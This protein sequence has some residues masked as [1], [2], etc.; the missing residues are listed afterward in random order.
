MIQASRK[1]SQAKVSHVPGFRE[2]LTWTQKLPKRPSE[3]FCGVLASRIK[4]KRLGQRSREPAW[5]LQSCATAPARRKAPRSSLGDD[6]ATAT[7]SLS[8]TCPPGRVRLGLGELRGTPAGP[9]GA[10]G[11]PFPQSQRASSPR[12][13]SPRRRRRCR[14]PGAPSL[15]A[16]AFIGHALC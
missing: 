9:P 10:G 2:A 14:P 7:K 3:M 13:G 15:R 16:A 12:A 8:H 1:A 6:L 5:L 4:A 11:T